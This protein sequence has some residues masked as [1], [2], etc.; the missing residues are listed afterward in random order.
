MEIALAFLSIRCPTCQQTDVLQYRVTA[1]GT[2]RYCCMNPSC[3]Q[4]TFLREYRHQGRVPAVK[5][6]MLE[7]TLYGS[8]IRDITRVLHVNPT[9]AIA[10]FKK[11]AAAP[12]RQRDSELT[13]EAK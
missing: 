8:G 12:T 6:Q 7:M 4:Q 13:L 5:Q 2:Q 3:P 11:S 9:T 1:Q 10:E